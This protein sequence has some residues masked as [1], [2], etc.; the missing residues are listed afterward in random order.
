VGSAAAAALIMALPPQRERE[1]VAA[2]SSDATAC[3]N[4]VD[5]FLPAVASVARIYRGTAG[6][7]RAELLQGGV[8]GLLRAV[9]RFEPGLGVP[10]WA[11]ASWWV[12]QAMQQLVSE[13]TGPA[14]LSD[15]AQRS[16]ARI[17]DGRRTYVQEHGRRPTLDELAERAGLPP[18]QV[19]SLLVIERTPLSLN[20]PV[21]GADELSWTLGDLIADPVAEEA[22]EQ[23]IAR[24]DIARVRDLTLRLDERE[25]AILY[26]HYGVG[27][28]SKTLS[29]IGTELGVSAERV[30]QIEEETFAKIRVAA[31]TV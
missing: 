3:A 28:P 24:L 29:E 15:R 27:R 11:Y 13:V 25:R 10:F 8:L 26:D 19:E 14:V 21:S 4:L 30:R 18:A 17:Q 9:R 5:A 1:L 7:E 2:A 20:E 23:V 16:L 6:V 12:R 31:A 22:Y